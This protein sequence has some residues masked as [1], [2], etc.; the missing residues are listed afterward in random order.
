VSLSK[1]LVDQARHLAS[2]EPKRPKQASLR[3][4]ISAAYYALF[5]HLTAEAGAFLVAGT[6]PER[7]LLRLTVSRAFDHAEMKR[8]SKA[9]NS[10]NP[11]Q[12]WRR[13]LAGSPLTAD[14]RDVAE[15]FV[16]LQEARHQADYDLSQTY[17]RQEVM[18]L[19]RRCEEAFDA[20]SRCRK[21]TA[22]EV[23]LVALLV[24]RQLR[25]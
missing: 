10:G 7:K 1:D 5:H 9:F 4:A 8:I 17:N 15:A 20:W 12:A 3:R 6:A 14:L 22:A 21:T 24:N 2:K 11:P 18:E 25:S 13:A 19:V 16:E 23:Y